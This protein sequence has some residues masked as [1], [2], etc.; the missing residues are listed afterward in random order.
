MP[1][2]DADPNFNLYLIREF[3]DSQTCRTI[4]AEL[5]AASERAATVYGH[6]VSG[7]VDDK[8]RKTISL[9]PTPQ[10]LNSLNRLL[11]E[12]RPNI[13]AHFGITAERSETPQ[14]LRYRVGDFFVAHQDGNTGLLLSERERFRKIS[15]VVFL[16]RE[17]EAAEPGAF[18]GGSL[19]FTEWRAGR[20][21]GKY[22][23]IPEEGMLVAFPAET[24]HEVIPVTSGERYSIVS[25]YG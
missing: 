14:F 7:D 10:T 22:R 9:N 5:S 21:Q 23:L 3:L 11:T 19:V 24:T 25:W 15:L 4:I 18:V 8:V 17:T 13:C 16:N 1:T 20:K 6:N 12:V 2:V